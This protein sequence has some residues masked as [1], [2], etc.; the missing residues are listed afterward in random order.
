MNEK[1]KSQTVYVTQFHFKYSKQKKNNTLLKDIYL[2]SRK[3]TE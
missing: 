2:H 3:E 1:T